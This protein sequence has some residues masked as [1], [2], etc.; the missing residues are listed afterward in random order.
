L[1]IL[2]FPFS[3]V[4]A[5]NG[6]SVAMMYAVIHGCTSHFTLMIAASSVAGFLIGAEP[7]G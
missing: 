6:W 5:K 4:T 3:S 1:S 2:N 7:A